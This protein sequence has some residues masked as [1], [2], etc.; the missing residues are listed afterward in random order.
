[1]SNAPPVAPPSAERVSSSTLDAAMP[2]SRPTDATAVAGLRAT[3]ESRRST[4]TAVSR[5]GRSR[6]GNSHS[7]A[8]ATPSRATEAR[9]SAGS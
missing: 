3:D 2:H 5:K 9:G 1:M 8:A 6:R 4:S 7:T